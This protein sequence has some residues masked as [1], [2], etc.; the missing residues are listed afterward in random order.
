MSTIAPRIRGLLFG[1]AVLASLGFGAAAARA[2]P[3]PAERRAVCGR[4][5]DAAECEYCCNW[6][7]YHDWQWDGGCLCILSR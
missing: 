4:A 1:T 5:A 2:E 3:G 7:G 6:Y